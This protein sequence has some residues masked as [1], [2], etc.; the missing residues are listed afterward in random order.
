ME[1]NSAKYA[2]FMF[3]ILVGDT[4][5]S[6]EKEEPEYRIR[7]KESAGN[8]LYSSVCYDYK[9]GS[10]EFRGCR[11]QAKLYFKSECRAL[12]KE[13]NGASKYNAKSI[14]VRKNKLCKAANEFNP[15]SI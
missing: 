14:E 10:I 11:K 2:V 13:I 1:L 7:W 4:S 6:T 9:S 12:S 8:I 15:I 5:F 3:A